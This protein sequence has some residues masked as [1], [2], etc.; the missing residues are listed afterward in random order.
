MTGRSDDLFTIQTDVAENIAA[1]LQVGLSTEERA[2]LGQN[3]L[4]KTR[5][6]YDLYLRGLAF[7]QLRH[8]DDNDKAI[9]LFE[10][11]LAARLLGLLWPTSGSPTHTSTVQ[12]VSVVKANW[13][14][15]AVG[16]L[17]TGDRH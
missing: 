9:G 11:A 12:C 15:S 17:P 13:L 5:I 3:D 2:R 14:D 6:A 16:S 10:Q 4:P 7:W 1:A 8:K